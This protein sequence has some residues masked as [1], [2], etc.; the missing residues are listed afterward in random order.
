VIQEIGTI[1]STR[2]HLNY[3]LFK[4]I[5]VELH[6]VKT[7]KTMAAKIASRP[8]IKNVWPIEVHPMPKPAGLQIIKAKDLALNRDRHGL[9][10]RTNSSMHKDVFSTHVMTQVDK[11]HAEGFTGKGVKVAVIDTGVCSPACHLSVTE[12]E[13]H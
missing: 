1:G 12:G 13:A 5:S 4:G 6:N 9:S 2:M 11:L 10:A 7:A 3:K 8:A